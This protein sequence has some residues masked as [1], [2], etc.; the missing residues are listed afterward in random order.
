MS[1]KIEKTV[2]ESK[3]E[4]VQII[5]ASHINGSDRLFGGRLIE[6]IDVVA[7]VVA[8]RHSGCNVTTAYIDNLQFK[9]P[10]YINDTVL[11]IGRVTCTGTTSM[12]VRVDTFVESLSMEKKLVNRAYFV[13]VA[14]DENEK[15][16][17]V[18]S[19]ILKTDEEREEWKN[20]KQRTLRR[21][22]EKDSI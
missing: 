2:E 18:P 6:W 15:P 4:H 21:K 8:R 1:S 7:G 16:T 5:M 12:E 14:L 11:I 13:M 20:G 22:Q 9:A 10:V 17:P 19:L 3:T